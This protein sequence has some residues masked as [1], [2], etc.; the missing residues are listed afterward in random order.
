[1]QRTPSDN[2]L[3]D[4]EKNMQNKLVSIK[5]HISAETKLI[6]DVG[7]GSG[8]LTYH[9]AMAFPE[10]DV[11]GIDKNPEFVKH[12]Q[13]T[14]RADNLEYVCDD[15]VHLMNDFNA[16]GSETTMI[17]SSVMH[18]I[19]SYGSGLTSVEHILK[20]CNAH[21]I[22]I[23]DFVAPSSPD[24]HI[25]MHHMRDDATKS[26]HDFAKEF[27]HFPI[28]CTN[29]KALGPHYIYDTNL[30]SVYEYIYRK[31]F[32]KNWEYELQEQYGFWSYDIAKHVLKSCG[33]DV[34]Y[35]EAINNDWILQNRITPYVTLYDTQ[36]QNVCPP[37]YQMLLVAEK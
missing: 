9:I 33:Y 10:K 22:I 28:L 24:M 32:I 19:Y 6:I 16:T 18:E 12:A 31:D 7:V 25:V 36:G 1:M 23:R 37:T 8:L 13:E 27:R 14:Y 29:M 26:F 4:M 17:F 21:R 30:R 15:V 34:A 3:G 5:P 2:Y 20:N 35:H 11:I